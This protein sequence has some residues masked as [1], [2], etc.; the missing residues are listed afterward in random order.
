[1]AQKEEKDQEVETCAASLMKQQKR[2]PRSTAPAPVQKMAKT[3]V[4]DEETTTPSQKSSISWPPK[5][6]RGIRIQ[7]HWALSFPTQS[8]LFLIQQTF[9]VVSASKGITVSSSTFS[10]KNVGKRTMSVV[11][12]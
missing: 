12:T 6:I 3:N 10:I 11:T 7:T 4:E 9:L 5:Y 8:P 2:P 1:M